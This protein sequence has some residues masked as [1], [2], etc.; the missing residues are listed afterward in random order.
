MIQISWQ[1]PGKSKI[2]IL[3]PI[4]L[5]A[6][7]IWLCVGRFSAFQMQPI[8]LA[9]QFSD[10]P[11]YGCTNFP[12]H[13]LQFWLNTL[14]QLCFWSW[15]STKLPQRQFWYWYIMSQLFPSSQMP[16]MWGKTFSS[17]IALE[18][19]CKLTGYVICNSLAARADYWIL[20]RWDGHRAFL[21]SGITWYSL[22]LTFTSQTVMSAFWILYISVYV[23]SFCNMG[24][25]LVPRSWENQISNRMN[26]KRRMGWEGGWGW[27][28]EP[29]LQRP[30]GPTHQERPSSQLKR[31]HVQV[32]D[33]SATGEAAAG[34]WTQLSSQ[35]IS[36]PS[37]NRVQVLVVRGC[38]SELGAGWSLLPLV[39]CWGEEV[40][41]N[42]HFKDCSKC[43]PPEEYCSIYR[44]LMKGCSQ[45]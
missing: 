3:E 37:T 15:R 26:D 6:G 19:E 35:E 2:V 41:Q 32:G 33:R 24:E 34:C 39:L 21:S 18:Q 31:L 8:Y 1:C 23:P 45:Y 7:E 40:K 27:R 28:R 29:V 20:C 36:A 17:Q 42:K 9:R 43:S 25:P 13:H 16:C 44:T 4:F 11:I 10:A 12:M 30:A 22:Q 14:L 5:P 38:W